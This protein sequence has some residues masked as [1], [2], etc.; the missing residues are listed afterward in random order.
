MSEDNNK[1]MKAK[2]LCGKFAEDG[3]DGNAIL[4]NRGLKTDELLQICS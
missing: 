4:S 2:N 1:T 3:R